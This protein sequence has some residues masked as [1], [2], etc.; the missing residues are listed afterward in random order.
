MSD[1]TPISVVLVGFGLGGRVFHGPLLAATP[2]LSLDG[3]VTADPR[4]QEQAKSHYPQAAIY[5]TADAAWDAG[6]QLAVI[7]TA[8]VT[9]KPYAAAA[10]RAGL[11][12]VLDKP[13]VPTVA[14]LLELDELAGRRGLL[15]IPF[16]NRRWDSDFLTVG[17]V[18]QSGALGTVHR[19][20]SRIQRMRPALSGVWR[21][22]P[23]PEDMGGALW[24][25]GPH[26]IDQAIQLLGPV[27]SVYTSSNA[28]RDPSGA[29]DDDVV[30]LRHTCGA[31]SVLTVSLI[32]AFGEPRFTVLGTRGG[33]RIDAADSQERELVSGKRPA[34]GMPWGVEPPTSAGEL[35][36][37]DSTEPVSVPLRPG[38]WP[39]FYTGVERAVSGRGEP[40]VTLDDGIADMRVIEAAKRSAQTGHAV[41]LDPPARHRRSAIASSARAGD[42]VLPG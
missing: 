27:G 10:L 4:R 8:N 18:V 14:D 17:A 9:H 29:D 19:F 1:Q 40:P 13:L 16:Q 39:S 5:A 36:S 42:Q 24:D 33:L 2:G 41:S 25:L 20:E 31:V 23:R 26:V 6:H 34:P 7:S 28:V 22:S 3:V 38:A 30:L 21:E 15:L 11:H 12:V 35:R 37:V 32:A